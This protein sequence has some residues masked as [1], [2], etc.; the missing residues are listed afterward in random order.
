[1]NRMNESKEIGRW[2]KCPSNDVTGARVTSARFS[3]ASKGLA[4]SKDRIAGATAFQ[5]RLS[6]KRSHCSRRFRAPQGFVPASII[7]VVSPCATAG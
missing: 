2:A 3:P 6:F 7:S 4:T 1:M 5:M